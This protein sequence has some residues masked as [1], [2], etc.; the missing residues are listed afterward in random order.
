LRRGRY[1]ITRVGVLTI[2]EE[3]FTA[4]RRTFEARHEVGGTAHYRPDREGIV[5]RQAPDRS[6]VP[7]TEM[8]LKLIE[9]YRPEVV[10]SVVLPLVIPN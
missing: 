9:D 4:T 1:G 10:T 3:E 8:T 2:I 5:M 6:N 7:A